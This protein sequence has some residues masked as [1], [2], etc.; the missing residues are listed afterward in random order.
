MQ[1]D[2]ITYNSATL[3]SHFFATAGQ[4]R[5]PSCH[6]ELS[7]R[8]QFL[9]L[10][11]YSWSSKYISKKESVEPLK[12][13]FVISDANLCSSFGPLIF[14]Q[15]DC[16]DDRTRV[17]NSYKRAPKEYTTGSTVYCRSGNFLVS[18]SL[19]ICNLLH[20]AYI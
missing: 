4:T 10:Q 6:T 18:K 3:H 5:W 7:R 12:G 19:G 14:G 1:S 15:L 20:F 16:A 13:H 2:I 8:E 11:Q 17:S 9:S